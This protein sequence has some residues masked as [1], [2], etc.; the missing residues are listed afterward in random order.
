[1]ENEMFQVPDAYQGNIA[2]ITYKNRAYIAGPKGSV[3]DTNNRIW[4]FDYSYENLNRVNK[5]AWAPWSGLN[6]A[7]FTIY[8]NELYYATSDDTGFVYKMNQ[9]AA[10]DDG[11]AIDSYIWTKEYFGFHDDENWV[12]DWRWLNLYYVLTGSGVLKICVRL[13]SSGAD[14]TALDTVSLLGAFNWDVSSWG[15]VN[16]DQEGSSTEKKIPLGSFRG[17]RIQFKIT[18]DSVLN[19]KFSIVGLRLNYNL[20]GL[21]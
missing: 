16:W 20:R 11:S 5:F 3:Q 18:N 19:T 2:S 9:S 1:M 12:K 21:R 10:N 6:A 13:D 14:P 8:G 15:E 17:K 7:D 4:Y